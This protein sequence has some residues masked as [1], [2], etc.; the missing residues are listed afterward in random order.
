VVNLAR[1]LQCGM[2]VLGGGEGMGMGQVGMWT[3][4]HGGELVWKEGRVR[5][6]MVCV[7]VVHRDAVGCLFESVCRC[8]R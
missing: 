8:G 4:V 1:G 7:C 6:Q 3:M 5:Q 2:G